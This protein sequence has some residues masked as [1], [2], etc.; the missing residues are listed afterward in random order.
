MAA[1]QLL[2]ISGRERTDNV[3]TTR[4]RRTTD[5]HTHINQRGQLI[6]FRHGQ[7]TSTLITAL[8][9]AVP[10]ADLTTMGVEQAFT[11]GERIVVDR[12]LSRAAVN[13]DKNDGSPTPDAPRPVIISSEALRATRTAQLVAQGMMNQGAIVSTASP[14][15]HGLVLTPITDNHNDQTIPTAIPGLTEVVAGDLEMNTDPESIETYRHT[16]LQ[17]SKGSMHVRMPGGQTGWETRRRVLEGLAPLL[18]ILMPGAVNTEPRT[19][20]DLIAVI[21][22]SLMRFIAG[23]LAGVEAHFVQDSYITNCRWIVL[24]APAR[25]DLAHATYHDIEQSCGTWHVKQWAWLPGEHV[26]LQN[27]DR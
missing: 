20:R 5:G 21:H 26:R 2:T 13:L 15:P 12:A 6:L 11:G 17:W 7:T 14:T 10:G 3:N 25:L 22:G 18:P 24:E 8:D 27:S 4:H 1:R 19:I 23:Q 9:T 16:Q